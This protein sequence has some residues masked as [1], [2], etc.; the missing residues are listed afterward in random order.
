[1]LAAGNVT[2]L[3]GP[4]LVLDR[5][6][7]SVE[8]GSRIGVLGRNGAGK[9]TLLRVLAGVE[10]PT[11]GV[12]ERAPARLT[13]GYLGQEVEPEGLETT[14]AYLRRRTGVAGAELA[15]DASLAAMEERPGPEELDAYDRALASLLA[16]GGDGL[17]HP[18]ARLLPHLAPSGAVLGPP[19][20]H[21]PPGQ[22]ARG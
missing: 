19:V 15:L 9:S 21:P 6:D 16:L 10:Q 22:Q 17:D 7:L 12:V 13:A 11:G 4:R 14:A 18:P 1:M 20:A 3:R 2:V 5:V 8:A